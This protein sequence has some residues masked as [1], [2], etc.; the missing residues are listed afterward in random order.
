MNEREHPTRRE[1]GLFLS[2]LFYR[3]FDGRESGCR[4]VPPVCVGTREREG[5]AAAPGEPRRSLREPHK[6]LD[7]KVS[8]G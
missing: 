2:R 5:M 1:R 6:I 3:F 4:W 7:K 8:L